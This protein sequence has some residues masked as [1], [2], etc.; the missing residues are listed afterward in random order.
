MANAVAFSY[1]IS[2]DVVRPVASTFITDLNM[3]GKIK[4]RCWVQNHE[5]DEGTLF[6]VHIKT[7]DTISKLKQA[8]APLLSERIA[9]T[10]MKLW[11]VGDVLV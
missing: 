4:L 6:Q 10:H 3:C 8:I 5:F 2:F 9:V 1:V 11:K 7:E